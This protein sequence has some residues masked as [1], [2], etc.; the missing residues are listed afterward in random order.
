MADIAASVLAQLKSKASESGRS[1]QRKLD[2]QFGIALQEYLD[3][4]RSGTLNIDILNT[5]MSSIEAFEKDNPKK[6]INL[7]ISA[8]QFIGL[9]NCIFDFTKRLAEANNISAHSIIRP[10][11]FQ[12]KTPMI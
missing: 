7:N 3:S 8:A 4:A 1:Y 10:K 12:K 2:K 11:Y 5:L 6:A 9:I